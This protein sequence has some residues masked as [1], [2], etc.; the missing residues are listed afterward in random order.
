[1]VK[2]EMLYGGPNISIKQP[3]QLTLPSDLPGFYVQ[4]KSAGSQVSYGVRFV[5]KKHV[6]TALSKAGRDDLV[7]SVTG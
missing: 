1:M 5:E 2:S 7:T 3:Y 6:K 4:C